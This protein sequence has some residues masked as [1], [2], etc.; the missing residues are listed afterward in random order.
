[1]EA[2]PVLM[3]NFG[4]FALA[5]L[6]SLLLA[7]C[8]ATTS[9]P[10]IAT[11]G[12]HV[13]PEARPRPDWSRVEARGWL[14]QAGFSLLLPPGWTL[15]ELQGMDSYV[16]EITGDGISLM[17]DYGSYS[18]DLNPGSEQ[19][20]EYVVAYEDIGGREAKLLLAAGAPSNSPVDYGAATAVYFGGLEYGNA[21]NV[22]GLELTPAQQETAVAI[23][24]SIRILE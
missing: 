3:R 18:W 7:A 14:D 24:R 4:G 17:F 1:M 9:V 23:F 15:T 2:S 10:R 13:A 8:D 11:D 6:V 5:S 21:L 20:H 19:E 12:P 16:G 22:V